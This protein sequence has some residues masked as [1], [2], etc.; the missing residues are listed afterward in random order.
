MVSP[1]REAI[2]GFTCT[3]NLGESAI[4]S[5]EP[6]IDQ[7]PAVQQLKQALQ[8]TNVGETYRLLALGFDQYL[9]RLDPPFGRSTIVPIDQ[10]E[11][12]RNLYAQYCGSPQTAAGPQ[13]RGAGYIWVGVFEIAAEWADGLKRTFVSKDTLGIYTEVDFDAVREEEIKHRE[14]IIRW[15]LASQDI[16]LL[17]IRLQSIEKM[18][19]DQSPRQ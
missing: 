16:K 4:S 15:F 5:L 8:A 13:R 2:I 6:F 12:Y 17:S 18:N 3:T 10:V 19:L 14:E 9:I 1:Q 7:S 11:N